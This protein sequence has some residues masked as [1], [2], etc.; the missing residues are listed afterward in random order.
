MRE[1]TWYEK[2]SAGIKIPLVV[3][4]RLT[5]PVVDNDAPRRGWNKPVAL[6]QVLVHFLCWPA[7]VMLC[8]CA[9]V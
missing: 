5:S 1:G 4:M 6:V 3:L 7:V 8:W 2:V 9:V